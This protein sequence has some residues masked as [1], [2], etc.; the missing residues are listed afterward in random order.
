MADRAGRILQKDLGEETALLV[1]TIGV[2][3]PDAGRKR[4]D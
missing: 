4:V 1:Q 3:D 2:Y